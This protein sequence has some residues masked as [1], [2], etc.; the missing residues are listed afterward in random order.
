MRAVL[1][2]SAA[3]APM[4]LAAWAYGENYATRAAAGERAALLRQIGALHHERRMLEG[5]LAYLSR[6]ERLRALAD[7]NF[8]DLRLVPMTP[9]AFGWMQEVPDALAPDTASPDAT[10]AL[11]PA[12]APAPAEDRP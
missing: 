2:I 12:S 7:L 1:L 6:P 4:A 11:I 3:M 8:A 9:E 10:E 5:E